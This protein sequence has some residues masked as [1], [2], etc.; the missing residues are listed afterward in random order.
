MISG[1]EKRLYLRARQRHRWMRTLGGG[2][3]G[4]GAAR[5]RGLEGV[6]RGPVSVERGVMNGG[7]WWVGA[8]KG[9]DRVEVV[10]AAQIEQQDADLGLLVGRAH[11]RVQRHRRLERK[12][13]HPQRGRPP[14]SPRRR[15]R[16]QRW[17]GHQR[18]SRQLEQCGHEEQWAHRAPRWRACTRWGA[19]LGHARGRGAASPAI[20]VL[21][22]LAL[23]TLVQS[24]YLSAE[25]SELCWLGGRER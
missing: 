2:C 20:T 1:S 22:W 17:I 21:A 15:L 11:V 12:R 25:T 6:V 14:A 8:Q 5:W 10:R 19:A 9:L 3:G 18:G 7:V 23:C 4:W 13:T 24:I 16:S